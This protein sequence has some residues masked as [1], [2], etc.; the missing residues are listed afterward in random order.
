MIAALL[1]AATLTIEDYATMPAPQSPDISPDGT[2]IAYVVSRADLKRSVYDR[3]VWLVGAD[4]ANDR[5]LTRNEAADFAPQWS[6]DGKRIAFLSDRDGG[7]NSI[8]LIEPDGG[9]AKRLTSEPTAIQ[10]FEWSPDGKSIAFLRPD[11]PQPDEEKAIKERDDARVVG[12]NRRYMHLYVA[13]V[14][15]GAVRRL[16]DGAFSIWLGIS[17]SPDSKTIAI[18]RAPGSGLDDLYRSDIWLVSVKDGETTPLVRRP[19]LDRGPV[20]SPDGKWVAFTSTGTHDWLLEHDIYVVPAAGGEPRN[21]SKAYGRTPEP[22]LVWSADSRTIWFEGPWNT[23]TQL[24]RVNADGTG[25][26]NTTNLEGVVSGIDVHPRGAA[27]IRQSLTEPPELFFAGKRLT[28]HN[29]AF[30]NRTLGETRLIRWKN[31]KDGLEIEALLTLPIGY[32]P[33]KRVPLLTFIHGGPASRFDQGFLGY[34]GMSYPPH[35]LASH[36][37][38]VLR[39]NPRGTGGYGAAFRAANR[40][41]WAAMPWLDI[42]TGIDKLIADGIADPKRLGV[43]GWS[44]GGY[45]ASWVLGHSERFRAFSIGAP[46]TDLLSFHGTADIRDFL[47]H[48]FDQREQPDTSLDEMRHAPLS[49]ELLRAQSPAWHLRP[50][51]AKVLIQHGEVDDR[52]PLSQGTL[53]YRLLDELGVDVTMVIYPRSAHALREPKLRMDVMK[54]NVEFFTKNV[55]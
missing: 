26:A 34:H 27:Y 51:P 30:R 19:G 6:P 46:V 28:D 8:W 22:P 9:E 11:A 47:P 48:Y 1:L 39:P 25:F 7:K 5:Q 44:Y 43:M 3:D 49:L 24:F 15:T 40:N 41:D 50:T 23:T 18:D 42:E 29:A 14:A 17:W 2:R 33:G 53:L 21:V 10:L 45:L 37:F 32:T 4:G 38:A 12:A 36:G 52:V 13:D 55:Q 31:P 20:F 54:R 16:T 35:V